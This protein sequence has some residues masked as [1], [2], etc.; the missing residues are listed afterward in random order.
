M[1]LRGPAV[2]LAT[3]R[4]A[5]MPDQR[6]ANFSGSFICSGGVNQHGGVRRNSRLPIYSDSQSPV[7]ARPGTLS[8]KADNR[9][10]LAAADIIETADLGFRQQWWVSGRS[11]LQH[12][13]E[14]DTHTEGMATK[15][16]LLRLGQAVVAAIRCPWHLSHLHLRRLP[17]RQDGQVPAWC[18]HRSGVLDR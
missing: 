4:D 9:R 7:A 5:G 10:L 12:G 8:I 13:G 16:V 15:T 14:N 2:Q 11:S 17:R 18:A 6:G 1:P 3:R